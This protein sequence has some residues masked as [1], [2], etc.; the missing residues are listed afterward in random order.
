MVAVISGSG[1]GL[2][3]SS[4]LGGIGGSGTA[5]GRGNDRIYVNA[6]TG[7]LIVRAVDERLSTL[8]LD[9]SLVRTY[10]S[11]GLLDDDNGD[12][13]RLGVH[14]RV[15]GLTGTPNTAGSTITK[16]FGDGREVGYSYDVNLEAYVSTEGDGAHDTLQYDDSSDGVFW[17]W[18]DGSTRD[19]E[20]YD[21]SGRLTRWI[22]GAGGSLSYGYTGSLLT[23]ITDLSGQITHLDYNGTDL[24]AIRVESDH[25][26]QTLTRYF[27]DSLHRLRQVVVDL[28]PSDNAAALPDANGDGLYEPTAY[29]TYVTTYSYEGTSRRI[30]S[31]AQADGSSVAFTYELVGGAYRVKT[32]TDPEG[33]TTTYS[34]SPVSGTWS[35]GS[36]QPSPAIA[37]GAPKISYDAAG[38]G[39][40][41]WTSGA[42]VFTQRY[43]RASDTWGAISLLS[44][45]ATPWSLAV[46]GTA[47]LSVDSGGDALVAWL[48]SEGAYAAKYDAASGAWSAPELIGASTSY[49]G[50]QVVAAIRG[51][52]A[53]VLW[54]DANNH[55]LRATRWT[56]HA[57]VT[58]VLPTGA[59]GP[60]VISQL[61]MSIDGVGN[62]TIVPT[63][64]Y[65]TAY[66]SRFNAASGQWSNPTALEG[67]AA[68]RYYLDSAF[69]ANGDGFA[70]WGAGSELSVRR[71]T[72]ATNT[73]GDAIVVSAQAY[74][75]GTPALSVDASGNA[76][77]VWN[78]DDNG[79]RSL[80]ARHYSAATAS[81][82][83]DAVLA[84]GGGSPLSITMQG[85]SAVVGFVRSQG[86]HVSRFDGTSWS[87][88]QR[89]DSDSR[90][91]TEASV[92]M[93]ASGNVAAIWR[94]R[95]DLGADTVF[96]NRFIGALNAWSGAVART[97][98]AFDSLNP[99][100]VFDGN[101]NA[102]AGW[103][104]RDGSQEA[105]SVYVR[106]YD[107][108]TNTWSTL[109]ELTRRIGWGQTARD[110][111]AFTL[112]V[113]SQGNA[114]A[115]W[116]QRDAGGDPALYSSQYIDGEWIEPT[117]RATSSSSSPNSSGR[118]IVAAING[119]LAA[120]AWSGGSDDLC[121]VR[122]TA[123]GWGAAESVETLNGFI[124]DPTL[125]MDAAG[126]VTVA[127]KEAPN[128]TLYI[129]R[130]DVATQA[131]SGAT[132][133]V[134][135]ANS[136]KLAFST[137]GNGMAIWSEGETLYARRFLSATNTWTAATALTPRVYNS[138]EDA[139]L[140]L[141]AQGNAIVSWTTAPSNDRYT[142]VARFDAGNGTWSAPVTVG[143]SLGLPWDTV[144][145]TVV[146]VNGPHAAVAWTHT[147]DVGNQLYISRYKDGV[148]SA[149]EL[150]ETA[151]GAV[152]QVSITIDA[153]GSIGVLW[154][155]FDGQVESIQSKQYV[156]DA[157][158][159]TN[160][161]DALG[162]TTT[163]TIDHASRL[164]SVLAPAVNGVRVETRYAYDADG[165]LISVTEDPNGA[166]RVTTFAYDANGNLTRS[167][168]AL[169]NTVIR[170]YDRDN[171][172]STETT[173][174]VPDPDGTGNAEASVPLT[175]SYAYDSYSRLRF[176]VSAQGRVT[177]H[178]YES[179]GRGERTAT[180]IY[181]GALYA[182]VSSLYSLIEWTQAQDPTQLERTDFAYDFRGNIATITTAAGT[183]PPSVTRFFY[184]QRG[185]LLQTI[186]AR[187]TDTPNPVAPNLPYATT[188]TY[189]GLG[190]VLSTTQ[191]QSDT[192]LIRTSLY[193]YDDAN[194]VTTTTLANGLVT[195][196][197]YNRAG[198]L[199]RTENGT[200]AAQAS[201]GRT[202]YAYDA[203]G[204]LRIAT[205]PLGVRQ[206]Y[207]YDEAGRKV[208]E[209]DGD[210]TLKE[211]IYD[212]LGQV[213]KTVLY[214]QRI[215]STTL[216][217]LVNDNG[218]PL[219][220]SFGS[221]RAAAD[222][223]PSQDR[224]QRTI[225]DQIGRPAYTVDEI[226]AVT[227]FFYDGAGR[228]LEQ[229]RYANTAT[230]A[231]S[232]D[233]VRAGELVITPSADD[234]LT[235]YFYDADGKLL[236][237]LDP[238]GYLVENL[239]DPA[240][241]I[242]KRVAY[243]TATHPSYRLVGTLDQL[244]PA[245][246]DEQVLTPAQDIVSY[247]FY[248][249]SGRKRGELDAE[250]YLTETVYDPA[251][252]VSQII[253]YDRV[254]AYAD[255][256]STFATLKSAAAGAATHVQS[257]Q[258]DGASRVTQRT[259]HQGTVTRY[260]YDAVGNTVAVA[261]AY[262]TTEARSTEARYDLLGR[263]IKELTAE[264]RA[265]ITAGMTQEDI[266]RIWRDYGVTYEY[267]VAGRKVRA[268][269]RPIDGEENVTFYYY[270]DDNRLRFEVNALGE[271]KEHRY[272][273]FG[274]LTDSIAYT[275]RI[276]TATL[277]GGVLSS[278]LT[279]RVN[280]AALAGN[281]AHT[282]YTYTLTG[283]V[284][285]TRTR[286]DGNAA[287][288]RLTTSFY[289]AFGEERERTL[290][291]DDSGRLQSFSYKYDRRGSLVETREGPSLILGES[292][293]YDAFGRLTDLTDGRLN[294]VKRFEY[295]RLGREIASTGANINDR[296]ITTYD[297]F[298][299]T[300][301]VRNAFGDE[302]V[303][304]YD[305]ASRRMTMTTPEGMRITTTFNR[306]GQTFTVLDGLDRLVTYLYNNDGQLTSVSDGMGSIEGR[307]YDRA[308]RQRTQTDARGIV[309][310]FTYDAANRVLT[311]TQDSAAGGLARVT[312]Y[313][314]DG[315]GRLRRIEEPGGRITQN[316][317]DRAG[318]ITEVAIDPEGMNLRTGYSFDRTGNVLVVTE[319][320]G[321]PAQRRTQYI[322]DELG[323]RIEEIVDPIALGGTL[324]LRTRYKY[325]NSGN[326]TRKID[327]IGNSTWYVYDA[328]NRSTHTIDATG[329]VTQRTYDAEG[330]LI[331]TRLYAASVSTVGFGDVVTAVSAIR[332][333]S[334]DRVTQVVYD[335]DGRERF[336]IDAVGT[337][338]E[339]TFDDN[340]NIV[341]TR[342]YANSVAPGT[343]TTIAA[344]NVALAA[345]QN[346]TQSP[347][348]TDRVSWTVFDTRG[349]ARFTID[350]TGAVV[351]SLRD[352]AGNVTSTVAYATLRTTS[353]PTGLADLES[354][355]A[356]P[357]IANHIDNRTTRYWYDGA[358]REVFK[359]DGA[360]YLT[361]TR[362]NDALRTNST[363]L[364]GERPVIAA[365]ATTAQVRQNS[366]VTSFSTARD[367]VSTTQTDAAGR[368]MR[369]YDALTASAASSYQEYGYDAV[370]NRI[371][372]TDPRGV[373][374]AERDSNWAR[375][376]R[377]RL[378]FNPNAEAL[379]SFERQLLRSRYTTTHAYDA[380]GREL[381]VTDALG[382]V[383]RNAY[384]AAGNLVKITDPN[385]NVAFRYY[386]AAGRLRYQI[387]PLG[388][389]TQLRYDALG[390]VV[391]EF[392]YADA[393]TGTYD[394]TTS[395]QQLTNRVATDS[396]RDRQLT[397]T[398]DRSGRV[399]TITHH[400]TPVSYQEEYQ[401][402]AFGQKRLYQDRNGAQ[403]EYR[404]NG[405]GELTREILPQL[406]IVTGVL[407][408]VA[409]QW[410]RLENYF[411]YTAFGE[412]TL[413]R[414]ATGTT[415]QRETRYFYD[416][417]GLQSR[418]ELPQFA[419]YDRESNTTIAQTPVVQKFY[420]AAGNLTLEI[421][422]NRGRTVNYYDSRNLRVASVD[423]DNVLRE[424]SFDAV[425]NLI[426]ERT[427]GTRLSGLPSPETRPTAPAGDDYREL[428][429]EYNANNLRVRTQTRSETQFSYALLQI[430]GDGYYDAVVATL[431][432]YDANGNVVRTVDGNGNSTFSY[433]DAAGNRILQVDAA[434]YV[435]RWQ[436]NAQGQL[437]L[438]TRYAGQLPPSVR[439][440][441]AA[442]TPVQNILN[443]IPAGDD[444]I[445]RYEYDRLG[446]VRIERKLGI[447][448]STVDA[449]NGQLTTTTSDLETTF[450][451]DG[452]GNLK[453][454][455][456]P[457][458]HGRI[459]YDYDALGRKTRQ[460]DPQFLAY[461]GYVR[462]ETLW[463]Y[464][465]YGNVAVQTKLA[466]NA[467]DNREH[468]YQY[469][470]SG[471]LRVERDAAGAEINRD[472][473]IAGEAIRVSRQVTDVYG[474]TDI[475]RTHHCYDVLGRETHRQDV[476]ERDIRG[477]TPTYVTRET[478]DTRYN[479]HGDIEAKGSNGQYQE[480]YIYDRLGRLFWTNKENGTPRLHLYDANGNAVL[481]L[482]AINSDLTM[483]DD[484]SGLRP[485]V[486][487]ADA[488]FS[489]L[490][491]QMTLNLYDRRNL[492][493][494]V[495][496]P[497]M[498][499]GDLLSNPP[500]VATS[501]TQGPPAEALGDLALYLPTGL[502]PSTTQPGTLLPT[503]T[504]P[505]SNS[506][507]TGTTGF[508]PR[509]DQHSTENLAI[510]LSE[511][512]TAGTVND[513]PVR[514][515]ISDTV[516]PDGG[517]RTVREKVTKRSV[518][519]ILTVE[520]GNTV[521]KTINT[522]VE[523]TTRETIFTRSTSVEEGEQSVE[524][525]WVLDRDE[526]FSTTRD[527][528]TEAQRFARTRTYDAT[529]T[530]DYM[531]GS[532]PGTL[533]FTPGTSIN[534]D[535]Q[536]ALETDA[537][538]L[539]NVPAFDAWG[540]GPTTVVIFRSDFPSLRQEQLINGAGNVNMYWPG[541]GGAGYT[542]QIYKG[543]HLITSGFAQG[544][545]GQAQ[546]PAIASLKAQAPGAASGYLR[547]L[548][549]DETP[550]TSF[551]ASNYTFANSNG[552]EIIFEAPYAGAF[553]AGA[554]YEYVVYDSSGQPLNRVVGTFGTSDHRNQH[555]Y[556]V[557]DQT[558]Q[559]KTY[560]T[561]GTTNYSGS[562]PNHAAS[563][564]NN[565]LRQLLR[566][567]T[568]GA[569]NKNIISNKQ[570]YN[571]FGEVI[572]QEDALLNT[573]HFTYNDLGKMT[574]QRQPTTTIELAT[575]GTAPVDPTTRYYYNEFGELVGTQDANSELLAADQKYFFS[576]RVLVNGR[577]EKEF[578]AY[579]N[580]KRY[581]YD[582]LG[583]KRQEFDALN[584]LT[585]YSYDKRGALTQVDRYDAN[586][587]RYTFDS[588]EYDAAGNRIAHTNGLNHRERY[589]FDGQNRIV[590][591]ISFEGRE[592][593]YSYTYLSTIGGIGGFETTTTTA[594]LTGLD[595]LVD[596]TDYFGRIRY[597]R[598]LGGHEFTYE[599][600]NAGWLRRQTGTTAAT[601][602]NERNNQEIVYEYY[603]NGFLKSVAD[604]GISSYATFQYDRRGN[605][606][607]EAYS[608]TPITSGSQ[609]L[610]PYQLATAQYDAL[611]RLVS[612]EEAGKFS[613][614]YTYDAVGNR[615]SVTSRYWDL[616]NDRNQL[617]QFYYAYDRMN[618]FTITMGTRDQ[619][620]GQ[621]VRGNTGYDIQ[622]DALGRRQF[623]QSDFINK[624]TGQA[625]YVG[626]WYNYDPIDTV[627]EALFY[628][629]ANNLTGRALRENNAIG[630]LINYRE[631]NAQG[632]TKHIYY[633]YDRDSL[634]VMEEDRTNNDRRE[635]TTYTLVGNGILTG[636]FGNTVNASGQQVSNSQTVSL[637]YS[638]E[639]WDSYKES[640]VTVTATAPKVRGW[641]P[642][643][644]TY[645]YNSNGHIVH[646][647]DA[648]AARTI[649]Y[650]NN[651]HGQVLRRYEIDHELGSDRPS[652]VRNFYY[653]SGIGVG[654]VGNDSV[655]SRVDYAQSF[656]EQMRNGR[657][658]HEAIGDRV[659]PVTSADF[660]QNYQPINANYPGRAAG[661]HIVQE[662]ETLQSIARAVWGDGSLWYLLAD[663][664]GLD[665]N[666]RLVAGVRLTVPNVVTNIHNNSETFR[667]YDASL[668]LGDTTPTLP[669]PPPPANGKKGCGGFG[670][671][672]VLVV[673]I[674]VTVF[675]AGA[676]APASVSAAGGAAAG[677]AAGAGG[678][679]SAGAAVLGGAGGLAGFGA[680]VAGG[681]VGAAV[682]QG[683]AIAAGLQEDFD[684]K[685]VA[686]GAV[687]AGVGAGLGSLANGSS[688]LQ[689]A[690][691]SFA[692]KNP[693]AF[694]AMNGAASSALTQ[695][696]AVATDMQ[697]S[698]SWRN[699][700]ISS[701]AAP[702]A[703]AFGES[704]SRMLPSSGAFGRQVAS[705]IGGSLVRRAF[706]SR[707]DSASIVLDAFGNALGNTIVEQMGPQPTAP[708]LDET[709]A[710][711]EAELLAMSMPEL[712]VAEGVLW[713]P[714]EPRIDS[715]LDQNPGF[716][717]NLPMPVAE[718]P[719]DIFD[720]VNPFAGA[721]LVD[722]RGDA[723]RRFEQL[724]SA[725][726][727]QEV[728]NGPGWKVDAGLYY[729]SK[730]AET[731]QLRDSFGSDPLARNA[732][733]TRTYAEI[734]ATDAQPWFGLAV[735]ASAKVGEGLTNSR[736]GATLADGF[737]EGTHGIAGRNSSSLDESLS[738]VFDGFAE[739]NRRVFEDQY[740]AYQIY[741]DG[742]VAAL[743]A[744]V[745]ADVYQQ[746]R[747][748][749]LIAGYEA[750][751]RAQVLRSAGD[752]AGYYRE[753]DQS[754]RYLANFEQ[755]TILQPE[756]D[757]QVEVVND[758][759]E[760][761]SRSLREAIHDSSDMPRWMTRMYDPTEV[762]VL[763]TPVT[764]RDVN[765]VDI[766]D[767]PERMKFV[768][769]IADEFSK[770]YASPGGI[771]RIQ[772]WHR[773]LVDR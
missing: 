548:N 14:Q 392:S 244:R 521:L 337:V 309:T 48:Q 484:G 367:R 233:E 226:G 130:F 265:R 524:Q 768:N 65:D 215:D 634:T 325:D 68:A 295:D 308:G 283:R 357:S 339:R 3:G 412:M 517:V 535:Y 745:E 666:E 327:A 557:H 92:T 11:Q 74:R 333:D 704:A 104:G 618:R 447:E 572:S 326:L 730:L 620:T 262:D 624:Q 210:G 164:S 492:L 708:G 173:Y 395:L 425:G 163:Y 216:R 160:V 496:Q 203:A 200:A 631:Y 651:H 324:N 368:V 454:E 466:Q 679:V 522:T 490:D 6:A 514:E 737:L 382:G 191:W 449:A 711:N 318:Q 85:A 86:L 119:N 79:E 144:G 276:S 641:A 707:E 603:Q 444:R 27:Y 528:K 455:I 654:D 709:R 577:L 223:N 442:S 655:P 743:K 28:T 710:R 54:A 349:N 139:S 95:G 573:T 60:G 56:G 16:V 628:D 319:G 297:A 31:I 36:T 531:A 286:V 657:K 406:E 71:Y 502:R 761:Y 166:N 519:T 593:D 726:I 366:V 617:Q 213:V 690:V 615:R 24:T 581:V 647:H 391:D 755:G 177:E 677:A 22:G 384:D 363:I 140:A 481:Q 592:T 307:T 20:I 383:T 13:W 266:E 113:D 299:R 613:I 39:I 35:P 667:P 663:A 73:W 610:H 240:G 38:N 195:T 609:A 409:T 122:L 569:V 204:R 559:T 351:Q 415:Q 229:V 81:W 269:V 83:G 495:F 441:L 468:R 483:V 44:P 658:V 599:Y 70:L 352:A 685:G 323:R 194:R 51:G 373:E 69:D 646:L 379:T 571:A 150:L 556:T 107:R 206:F 733:Y 129:N 235:R 148:W 306:H 34:D 497:P 190:R 589:L 550:A 275:T 452:N 766:G 399:R 575:G 426:S 345:A 401:Y 602:A 121:V 304:Q 588:Y 520:A 703:R 515:T 207:L 583:N 313:T 626:E 338:T 149:P 277:T 21:S 109:Q 565:Y 143:S 435:I 699:V 582:R 424:F 407:P 428:Q 739:G 332:N 49:A 320:V 623:V 500:T 364:Y 251:G 114:L 738:I 274:R 499:F 378:G 767:F 652:I 595:T 147:A 106:H 156:L 482:H 348:S 397:K 477:T 549:P 330:R 90:E 118:R 720:G 302:T 553:T 702:A 560:V 544:V 82:S 99:Q 649:D 301:R 586:N 248:D 529:M 61:R 15:Y 234:R 151:T 41:V 567:V 547:L 437:W 88:A 75:Y 259:D 596:R 186:D 272:D 394:E 580:A 225:Y 443:A 120:I 371:S 287:N 585:S 155:Q 218:Q 46:Q 594:G 742:G 312:T 289:N 570:T 358:G 440:S 705:S 341:R 231:R 205:D 329:S 740:T 487:P 516:S 125:G 350:A 494:Q 176:V 212:H 94:Q 489:P 67:G 376:E 683:V 431:T 446:R 117:V 238:M 639:K 331:A 52:T 772:D 152:G 214:A 159:V 209:I 400:A 303:Y 419:V 433:F 643:T 713:S 744:V 421:A 719:T 532:Y 673:A 279:N 123:S 660:D 386:D 116:E 714:R 105:G 420:D 601:G 471:N 751:D 498:V 322:Y 5:A 294:V 59:S 57:W 197:T 696:V 408:D 686:L 523:V 108:A 542:V 665:G 179:S 217:T 640:S 270:D 7:N 633:E 706:G 750:W 211:L 736:W 193:S 746:G 284:E 672:L 288:D 1:L 254:L 50:E 189:D 62:I 526:T 670:L 723:A 422:A 336:T 692:N 153:L 697:R 33:R 680:A 682:S 77:V 480:K 759:G 128:T 66:M 280:Q 445:T 462:E 182:G 281:H 32:Y 607:V 359:L 334:A 423:A 430:T 729:A 731:R 196:D 221:L 257:Y 527:V 753:A 474:R 564:Q 678:L 255:G 598:D 558:V 142:H 84:A 172:L 253:R 138:I 45:P 438:D 252:N 315:Q 290:R 644:S 758:G 87:A 701:L 518:E 724:T 141:D 463:Q 310:T 429:Y 385:N 347:S 722:A 576:T 694:A 591:H 17:Y 574:V 377:T 486:G 545:S 232:V 192:R 18:T 632:Q 448:Y 208:G 417:R 590:R 8:G 263:V 224:I 725:A 563:L 162:R 184:D 642:G 78:D 219:E 145:S 404:Y 126:N 432:D 606:T 258:Y 587:T 467:A 256:A 457:N 365:A 728:V 732:G 93:D 292:R 760:R 546:V 505:I 676:L 396:T 381:S 89:V 629:A 635:R 316:S 691:S 296:T 614:T 608:Q 509:E 110:L 202:T 478:Y 717:A 249:A 220:V 645:R 199:I 543:G 264:G 752:M 533:A 470:T 579:G 700:A 26:T 735:I 355:A 662:G 762:N 413:R 715:P 356:Q 136:P 165:N 605:R 741:R 510:P 653:L 37:I 174:L 491:V 503:E 674:V 604:L 681:A 380:A 237:T 693:Y 398:Y 747:G 552:T 622:Y 9:L 115:V 127:F 342:G 58:D 537:W 178:R 23:Q 167:V 410:L 749:D 734:F 451:Y 96:V 63:V 748:Q 260:T 773:D 439:D 158:R 388:Y 100:I 661:S 754:L 597:H 300:L 247:F 25:Q 459:D 131:W 4:A 187:G 427:Y 374:L 243:A 185:Q 669:A 513:P 584:Q 511:L 250:G 764:T 239:Y 403:F 124:Y 137:D 650:V 648:Q 456:R 540:A 271:V 12:N 389:V 98:P 534:I 504:T 418:V 538:F 562:H 508:G 314:Y 168:D 362:Y 561:N 369:T 198:E 181:T 611:N 630:E 656:A 298:S 718:F 636:T 293:A 475:Y 684:W 769:R 727:A 183:A 688:A 402:N 64:G 171:Q 354:W 390:N 539:F 507:P 763:G 568:E 756:Y 135:W 721:R 450:E 689:Q 268:T 370:G 29:Q 360:G 201:L 637:Q 30:A 241:R 600:N 291:I 305:D 461:E 687:G 72:A 473:S 102:W 261:R 180:L 555:T 321:T 416:R 530:Y 42:N 695:G 757:R 716:F 506:G 453:A 47:S 76:V 146:A 458:G 485:V 273:A 525:R 638:Y 246:D 103:I 621:I 344:V 161:T 361:E 488:R 278:T 2:F 464:D 372:V 387:D 671:V 222:D 97:T 765:I 771:Q 230:I 227:R 169:G 414:E 512:G 460:R 541:G 501:G 346:D 668:A 375:G 625:E 393:L 91:V 436:Y 236:A 10:N 612:V 343:Y 712:S 472:Y 353:A 476:E 770:V 493:T 101:G 675:T 411:E 242:F 228:L 80:K 157:L 465:A 19:T 188:Y 134:S 328:D 53:A 554:K 317:Y 698:F 479:A 133:F 578:D 536:Y 40:A 43:T 619:N 175:T 245:R 170:T 340:G 566:T 434:G 664:N 111:G 335:R 311:R 627:R 267:D 55:G 285:T 469:D 616:L 659:T 282:T 154:R 551:W 405:R 132:E 112:A